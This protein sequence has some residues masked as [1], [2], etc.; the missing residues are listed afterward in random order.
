MHPELFKLPFTDLTVKSYG[1]MVVMGFLLALFLVKKMCGRVGIDSEKVT[2]AGFYGFVVGIIGARIFHVVHYHDQFDSLMSILA[3]WRGGLEL[4]GGVISTILFLFVYL[5]VKKMNV[6]L[7]MDILAVALMIGIGFGRLGCFFNGCCFGQPTNCPVGVVFPYESIPYYSQAFPDPA[8]NRG[9]AIIE[10]PAEFY[11]YETDGQWRQASEHRKYEYTLKPKHLLT[12]QQKAQVAKGGQYSCAAVHPTQLYSF[13]TALINCLIL[14]LFWWNIGSGQ[15]DG[16]KRR[17]AAGT[18]GAL[19]LMIY[20]ASRFVIE[21]LRGDNPF[22][23]AA[24]TVSQLL[25]IAIFIIGAGMF[26]G[27][28]RKKI[29]KN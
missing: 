18:T 20:S 8:R 5:R 7:V 17:F 11:G 9:E 21:Y 23:A 27:L 19:M 14:G 13:I 16:S 24:L 26:A 25:S 12:E 3:I 29:N 28:C 1:V 2:T 15:T 22:E 4:L 10:L 6:L